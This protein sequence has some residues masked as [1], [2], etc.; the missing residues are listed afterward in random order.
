MRYKDV[1]VA[2]NQTLPDI[3]IQ[4]YGDVSELFRLLRGNPQI[5]SPDA[6]LVEGQ[7]LKV[8]LNPVLGDNRQMNF[9]RNNRLRVATGYNHTAP[10]VPGVRSGARVVAGSKRIAVSFN[11]VLTNIILP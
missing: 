7:V 5:T 10:G 6:E 8:Q 11:S 1:I 4:E 3:T 9:F 2:S